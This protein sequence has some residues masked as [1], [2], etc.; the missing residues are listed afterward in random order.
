MRVREVAGGASWPLGL[1][2]VVSAS[3]GLHEVAGVRELWSAPARRS[4]GPAYPGVVAHCTVGGP[5]PLPR[6]V[7]TVPGA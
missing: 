6:A 1:S 7:G 4:G 5:R 3:G 2:S